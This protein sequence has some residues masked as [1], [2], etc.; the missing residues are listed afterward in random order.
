MPFIKHV[1]ATYLESRSLFVISARI[2]I[3]IR[4]KEIFKEITI[5]HDFHIDTFEIAEDH[6]HVFLSFLFCYSIP[7]VVGMLKSINASVLFKE[8]PDVKNEP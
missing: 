4:R 7:S 5:H 3:A 2:A 6:V 8:H 1:T